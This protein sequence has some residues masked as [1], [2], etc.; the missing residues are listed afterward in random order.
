[1]LLLVHE[2]SQSTFSRVF[3][4][5]SKE[6]E[7]D[8]EAKSFSSR[9]GRFPINGGITGFVAATKQIVNI[10]DAY[11]DHRYSHFLNL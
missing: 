1:M 2:G 11:S 6:I 3:D 4:L 5:E 7:S 8:S 10:K 9:D